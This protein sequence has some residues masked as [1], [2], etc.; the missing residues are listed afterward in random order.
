MKPFYSL[1]VCALLFSSTSFAYN[2]GLQER[3]DGVG[4][5][6]TETTI[7]LGQ[8]VVDFSGQNRE[9]L[10]LTTRHTQVPNS[11]LILDQK[12]SI[13]LLDSY[14]I[15]ELDVSLRDLILKELK[16]SGGMDDNFVMA[17]FVHHMSPA[18]NQDF[19]IAIIPKDI[20]VERVIFQVEW[21]GNGTGGHNQVRMVL[22][23]PITLIPQKADVYTSM[24]LQNENGKADIVYS[25]L[26]APVLGGEKGWGPLSGIMGEFSNA[27]QFFSVEAMAKRQIY[28]SVIDQHELT[29]LSALQKR[30][31]LDAAMITSDQLEETTIYN[32]ILN[33]CV[34]HSMIAL[35][36]SK[37]STTG[38]HLGIK[39]INTQI[40]NPYTVIA[41]LKETPLD[42]SG[43]KKLEVK[44]IIRTMN[45][46]FSQF[47][48]YGEI[49]TE[50]K[51]R[52]TN[53]YQTLAPLEA[54][55]FADLSVAKKVED[56]I[57]KIAIYIVD[58]KVTYQGATE[59]IEKAK[60]V[61]TR[62]ARAEDIFDEKSNQFF[63]N[64]STAWE[65]AVDSGKHPL[66]ELLTFLSSVQSQD[67]QKVSQENP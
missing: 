11:N 62:E 56:I 34:T 45:E 54:T 6:A 27:L 50:A 38:E 2:R 28:V 60:Q 55:L 63:N 48:A 35:R 15:E 20:S 23:Q 44:K 21:F 31:I 67:L 52:S 51:R 41:Q 32:T 25:L 49:M 29:N 13:K 65:A 57:R 1:F 16:S 10:T 64:I 39:N 59:F 17:N 47:E 7:S 58:N 61:A 24:I 42:A 3:I 19:F 9:E 33:S 26:A 5:I 40:F 37:D 12:R 4:Q 66:T 36:G 43:N 8:G 18:D 46:E 53:S 14:D 30:A 22:D